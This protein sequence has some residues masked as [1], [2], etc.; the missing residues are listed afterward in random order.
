MEMK[1]G[2]AGAAPGP[3]LHDVAVFELAQPLFLDCGSSQPPDSV[4]G[5]ATFPLPAVLEVGTDPSCE[6][7]APILERDL[8]QQVKLEEF[9]DSIPAW[10]VRRGQ[11]GCSPDVVQIIPY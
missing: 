6:R 10:Q 3:R 9:T 1:A 11:L 2:W 7:I 4:H 5:V 8:E